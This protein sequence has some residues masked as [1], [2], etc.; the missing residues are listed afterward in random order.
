MNRAS[1]LILTTHVSSLCKGETVKNI[2]RN[3]KNCV[4]STVYVHIHNTHPLAKQFAD[5]ARPKL[6]KNETITRILNIPTQLNRQNADLQSC[7]FSSDVLSFVKKFYSEASLH[8]SDIDI[9]ILLHNVGQNSGEIV[10]S[11]YEHTLKKPIMCVFVDLPH[12]DDE[13]RRDIVRDFVTS[14]YSYTL[15]DNPHEK[16]VPIQL[17]ESVK[18]STVASAIGDDGNDSIQNYIEKRES[19]VLGGTFDRLHVGHKVLL[20]ESILLAKRKIVIGNYLTNTEGRVS[21]NF[22]EKYGNI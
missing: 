7:H 15:A 8:C 1:L 22:E 14:K 18:T 4:V 2:I 13:G 19:V 10:H 21:V 16:K 12:M 9:N 5:E 17:L 6:N 11:D 20:S 3:V